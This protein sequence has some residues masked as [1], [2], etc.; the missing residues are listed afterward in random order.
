MSIRSVLIVTDINYDLHAAAVGEEL[1]HLGERVVYWNPA[2]SLAE[3]GCFS[4]GEPPE[5]DV[6][7]SVDTWFASDFKSVWIRR[8]SA[9]PDFSQI[10]PDYRAIVLEEWKFFVSGAW[11]RLQDSVDRFV[12]LP[13]NIRRAE[14][15]TSQLTCAI[16]LGLN[17]P[18]TIVSN[19]YDQFRTFYTELGGNVVAKKLRSH[20][21]IAADRAALFVTTPIMSIDQIKPD[22]LSLCPIIFQRRIDK[23][24]DSRVICLGNQVWAFKIEG[25]K[26]DPPLDYRADFDQANALCHTEYGLPETIKLACIKICRHFGLHFGAFDFVIDREGRHWFM[27]LNANGQWLWL[28]IATGVPLAHYF[29]TYLASG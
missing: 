10:V 25:S 29:A 2:D 5:R 21:L 1:K 14:A 16:K 6:S 26:A 22:E 11:D 20:Q 15:K 23:A 8:P 9:W 13:M 7:F 18:R 19:D 24:A 4:F 28:Q 12:S 3:A 27:E 17:V